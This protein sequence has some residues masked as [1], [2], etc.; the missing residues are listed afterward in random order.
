MVTALSF[1][2]RP[3]V[4]FGGPPPEKGWGDDFEFIDP[5]PPFEPNP[6]LTGEMA[7]LSADALMKLSEESESAVARIELG[8][9]Y[10]KGIGGVA[11]D[12]NLAELY[13]R[14][15]AEQGDSR[16]QYYLAY[17]LLHTYPRKQT[18]FKGW[19]ETATP[20]RFPTEP[21]KEAFSWLWLSTRQNL[22]RTHEL[23]HARLELS[24]LLEWFPMRDR[25]SAY[26]RAR[27]YQEKIDKHKNG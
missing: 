2:S 18:R 13:F 11:K 22:R 7:K 17:F 16:G 15:A 1:S 24:R 21:E 27:V 25:F 8:H 10:S 12:M 14:L 26:R 5:N 23:E 19:L 20:L 4:R 6:L 3:G 9:R